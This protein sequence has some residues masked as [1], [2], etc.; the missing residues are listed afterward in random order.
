[1]RR[2]LYAVVLCACSAHSSA[3]PDGASADLAANIDGGGPDEGVDLGAFDLATADAAP[4]ACPPGATPRSTATCPGAATPASNAMTSAVENAIR[5][6]VVSIDPGEGTAP[7][8][9]VPSAAVT[10]RPAR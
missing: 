2:A 9:P 10:E 4:P 8:V 1:M 5:G 6:D 7:C 3:P